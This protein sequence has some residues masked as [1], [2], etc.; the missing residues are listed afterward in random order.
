MKMFDKYHAEDMSYAFVS[1]PCPH[2]NDT[3]ALYE[4]DFWNPGL[5][6]YRFNHYDGQTL[7]DQATVDGVSKNAV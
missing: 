1:A 5:T 7:L 6:D 3:V 4:A 2:P